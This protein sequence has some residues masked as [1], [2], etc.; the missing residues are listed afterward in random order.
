MSDYLINCK[1]AGNCPDAAIIP[2]IGIMKQLAKK[3]E[4]LLETILPD[5]DTNYADTWRIL[6]SVNGVFSWITFAG[7]SKEH[8]VVSAA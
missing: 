5:F 4:I 2:N 1:T 3:D 6:G 8:G 7:S